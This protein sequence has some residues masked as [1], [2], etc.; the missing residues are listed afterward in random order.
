MYANIQLAS[1]LQ[2][3][4]SQISQM[5]QLTNNMGS[6]M[7]QI[8]YEKDC[9]NYKRF[10]IKCKREESS[11]QMWCVACKIKGS[12]S[13]MLQ[14]ECKMAGSNLQIAW[15]TGAARNPR[16]S[17]IKNTFPKPFPTLYLRLSVNQR[18]AKI[19]ALYQSTE[20]VEIDCDWSSQKLG[21]LA[22]S[23]EYGRDVYH[24]SSQT[25]VK[26]AAQHLLC[27]PIARFHAKPSC[28]LE[29]SSSDEAQQ[30]DRDV[31]VVF[32]CYCL[33]SIQKHW[34]VILPPLLVFVTGPW[35]KW[36]DTG[37][38]SECWLIHEAVNGA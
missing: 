4:T 16:K 23:K 2:G 27:C 20:H 12:S 25:Y 7:L 6:K 18:I 31:H 33:L 11:S 38:A 29:T 35:L 5:L 13:K 17:D 24:V 14:M 15:K 37:V 34:P 10:Q 3:S 22:D 9:S 1:K 19:Q 28:R 8:A 36:Y 32:Y 21:Q 30:D 26:W